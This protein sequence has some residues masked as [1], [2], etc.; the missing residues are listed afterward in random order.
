MSTPAEFRA[1]LAR[2]RIRLYDL[3]PRVGVH[4]TR[5]GAILNERIPL[6]TA[7]AEKIQEALG[8]IPQ[9]GNSTA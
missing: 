1:E 7:I 4:P 8:A 6:T 3:A 5:L 9:A 2:R